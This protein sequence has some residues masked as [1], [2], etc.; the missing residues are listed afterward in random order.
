[1]DKATLPFAG[2]TFLVHA[3]NRLRKICDD[4][5][6]SGD[7]KAAHD[8]VVIEDPVTHQGPVTGIAASLRYARENG[9]AACLITPV[10]TPTL[11]VEDLVKLRDHWQRDHQ[12]TIACSDRVEPLIGIYPVMLTEAID[13]LAA[14]EDRSVYRWIESQDHT[15]LPCPADH[16]RNINSPQD[17]PNHGC[18]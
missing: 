10:D 18:E 15:T 17:I 14:S 2:S 16:L 13:Q 1:M 11:T 6:V 12:L 9:F 3:I 5:V 8:L 4:V 7:T